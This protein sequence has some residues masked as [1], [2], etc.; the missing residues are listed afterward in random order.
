MRCGKIEKLL[1]WTHPFFWGINAMHIVAIE[2]FK[3]TGS[4]GALW[5]RRIAMRS[6]VK[7]S[8]LPKIDWIDWWHPKWR[9]RFF[10]WKKGGH[11]LWPSNN[12][13][14]RWRDQRDAYW[15]LNEEGMVCEAHSENCSGE[16][17]KFQ[18]IFGACKI[19]TICVRCQILMKLDSK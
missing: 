15:R 1:S 2:K 6:R 4:Y 18:K 7:S 12:R 10:F 8:T 13:G 17:P 11:Q 19:G 5:L 9:L 14:R 16:K 3:W